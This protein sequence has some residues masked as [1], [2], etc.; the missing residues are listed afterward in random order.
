M[1]MTNTSES[2]LVSESA[3]GRTCS[4]DEKPLTQPVRFEYTTSAPHLARERYAGGIESYTWLPAT[5]RG[6]RA[7]RVGS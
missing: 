6:P 1:S 4:D 3:L 2:H 5:L 7:R